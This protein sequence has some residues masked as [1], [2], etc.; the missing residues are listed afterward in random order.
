M[1]TFAITSIIALASVATAQFDNIP[2]CALTCFIGPLTTD[3]CSALTDFACHCKQGAKLLATVQPCVEGACSAAD[4][5][6][7]IAAVEKTCADAG[8]PIEIPDAPSASSAAP[9]SAAASS[10]V[11]SSA[12][13]SS[14][15]VSATPSGPESSSAPQ[16]TGSA[17]ASPT[18]TATVSTPANGTASATPTPSEYTGAAAQATQAAGLLGAA[19]LALLAL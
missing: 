8:A 19:A 5:E 17:S 6:T 3:G 9:S 18:A 7:T 12:A 2:S 1:K 16:A 15:V 14:S 13:P 10:I 4:K 11:P